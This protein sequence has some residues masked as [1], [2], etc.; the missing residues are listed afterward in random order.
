MEDLSVSPIAGAQGTLPHISKP[1]ATEEVKIYVSR[2]TN[3]E[4]LHLYLKGSVQYL[5]IQGPGDGWQGQTW[6]QV[7]NIKQDSI[8]LQ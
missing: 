8:T 4:T 1:H 6:T 3:T 7:R 2:A 5:I